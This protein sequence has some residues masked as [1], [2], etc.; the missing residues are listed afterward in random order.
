MNVIVIGV[1]AGV[2]GSIDHV[3]NSRDWIDHGSAGNSNFRANVIIRAISWTRVTRE[4]ADILTRNGS[5][6]VDLPKRSRLIGIVRVESVHAVVL[7][8][9][10]NHVVGRALDFKPRNVQGLGIDEP[11]DCAIEQLAERALVYVGS[12]EGRLVQILPGARVVT[13]LSQN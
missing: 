8:G 6:Q 2:L 1:V 10:V 3:D 13:V 11:I 12:I 5:T 7:R 4:N 9:D